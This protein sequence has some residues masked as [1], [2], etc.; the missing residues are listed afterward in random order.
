M[1]VSVVV[2]VHDA[3][4]TLGRTLACLAAQD[5]DGPYEVIVVDDGSSDGTAAL[6]ASGSAKLFDSNRSGSP[7]SATM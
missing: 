3:E 7:L 6:V 4:A 2:P 5:L 1:R